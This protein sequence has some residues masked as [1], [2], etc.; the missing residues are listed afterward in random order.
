MQ[1]VSVSLSDHLAKQEGSKLAIKSNKEGYLLKQS[2]YIKKWNPRYFAIDSQYT[3]TLYY[4]ENEDKLKLLGSFT[5]TEDAIL[6]TDQDPEHCLKFTLL[7]DG[8]AVTLQASTRQERMEW[9][10]AIKVLMD[11][12]QSRES[13]S[14]IQQVSPRPSTKPLVNRV[15]NA[16]CVVP[17]GKHSQ[18]TCTSTT[19]HHHT[20][21]S[22]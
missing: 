22:S 7:T 8:K 15:I 18:L 16:A 17:K 6:L 9:I 2:E 21:I 11:V 20:Y 13:M 1:E 12:K 19:Q 14:E 3:F 10:I 5:I 4:Y